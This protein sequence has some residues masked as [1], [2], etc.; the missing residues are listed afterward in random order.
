MG[1]TLF[2]ANS[3]S[4][5]SAN[6]QAEVNGTSGDGGGGGDAGGGG[7]S[8]TIIA[9]A[10]IVVVIVIAVAVVVV[11]VMTKKPGEATEASTGSGGPN[12]SFEN[13]VY[14]YGELGGIV[15]DSVMYDTPA[16]VD[17]SGGA[18]AGQSDAT[19]MEVSAAKGPM[20]HEYFTVDAGDND[21]LDEVDAKL[22]KKATR[23][24][25]KKLGRQPTPSE[26]AKK[27]NQLERKAAAAAR[28]ADEAE[29]A[30]GFGGFE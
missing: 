17:L 1:T 23:L 5:E 27:V 8:T 26:I 13:P 30:T 21:E 12:I 7:D 25:S 14:A 11:V 3:P 16:M 2:P 4:Q 29:D 15:A 22:K 24:L 20:T 28:E 19:Y 6:G 18:A 9:V 10:A